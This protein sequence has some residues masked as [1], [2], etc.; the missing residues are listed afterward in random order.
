MNPEQFKLQS[1][2]K[3]ER[4]KRSSSALLKEFHLKRLSGHE[5]SVLGILTTPGG[6]AGKT[7]FFMVIKIEEE[8]PALEPNSCSSQK[9]TN[10]RSSSPRSSN[11][12]T[13]EGFDSVSSSQLEAA[14]DEVRVWDSGSGNT[15]DP[16]VEEE[17]QIQL[18]LELSAMKY[19]SSMNRG[20]QLHRIS[21]TDEI[22]IEDTL[23]DG[24]ACTKE[25]KSLINIQSG[26]GEMWPRLNVKQQQLFRNT[27]FGNLGDIHPRMVILYLCMR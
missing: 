8:D 10:K 20:N 5:K 14:M 26:G 23:E 4:Y 17:Y 21:S 24:F 6:Q 9:V 7:P 22:V 2:E 12:E 1:S 13:I 11:L 25:S 27:P 16:E 3:R 15:R 19:N 18:A